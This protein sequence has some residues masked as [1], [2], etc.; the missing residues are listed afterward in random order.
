MELR[1]A[2]TKVL[3]ICVGSRPNVSSAWEASLTFC[4]TI[5]GILFVLEDVLNILNCKINIYVV[6]LLDLN[7]QGSLK[8]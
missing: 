1:F 5:Q 2:F 4:R 6:F 3:L 8:K 7:M